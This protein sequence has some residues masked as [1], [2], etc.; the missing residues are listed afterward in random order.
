MALLRPVQYAVTG[1]RGWLMLRIKGDEVF[2]L[3]SPATGVWG[4]WQAGRGTT[5]Q[6]LSSKHSVFWFTGTPFSTVTSATM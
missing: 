1:L 3:C 2:A 5:A 4:Y 6:L